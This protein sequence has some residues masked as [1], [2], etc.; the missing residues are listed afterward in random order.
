MNLDE[1]ITAEARQVINSIVPECEVLQIIKAIMT[2]YFTGSE[3]IIN[4][5]IKQNQ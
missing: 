1:G 4:T 2:E 5:G 3:S